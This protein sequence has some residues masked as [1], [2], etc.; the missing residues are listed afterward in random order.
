MQVITGS[1]EGTLISDDGARAA[2]LLSQA[3]SPAHADSPVPA[4]TI[5]GGVRA[6]MRMLEGARNVIVALADAIPDP[7]S[8]RPAQLLFNA[9]VRGD[10]MVGQWT[11][12]DGN[13]VVE[14][15]GR[16]AA[17]RKRV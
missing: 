14:S 11:R 7:I 17:V 12:R 13:G 16:I 2:F 3:A 10:Q 15:A 4:I 6:A 9:R 8:G 5:E 1:W